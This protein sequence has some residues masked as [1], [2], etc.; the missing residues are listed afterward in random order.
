MSRYLAVWSC[1]GLGVGTF[2]VWIG[3]LFFTAPQSLA[4]DVFKGVAAMTC[5]PL[6]FVDALFAPPLNAIVYAMAGLLWSR[7]RGF[8]KRG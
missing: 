7:L 1:V 3:F 8:G 6:L 4:V 2:W 5:P